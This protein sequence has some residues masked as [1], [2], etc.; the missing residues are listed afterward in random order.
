MESLP[1][2]Y[3]PIRGSLTVPHQNTS[4]RKSTRLKGSARAECPG[5][6]RENSPKGPIWCQN[7]A[8]SAAFSH[9]KPDSS[10]EPQ[11]LPRSPFPQR[12]AAGIPVCPGSHLPRK[13][14]SRAQTRTVGVVRSVRL[15]SHA[16][17]RDAKSQG[18]VHSG[19]GKDT[20]TAARRDQDIIG[21][22]HQG[23]GTAR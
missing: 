4:E 8:G 9:R 10:R 12:L 7:D 19:P 15:V 3:F 17:R 22:D 23:A 21:P 20:R 5:V 11:R 6:C 16:D 1:I 18:R 13:W 14:V 2:V